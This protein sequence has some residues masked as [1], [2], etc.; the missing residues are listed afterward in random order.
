MRL[1]IQFLISPTAQPSYIMKKI[2]TAHTAMAQ[3]V[4]SS[5]HQHAQRSAPAQAAGRSELGQPM[6]A[7]TVVPDVAMAPAPQLARKAKSRRAGHAQQANDLNDSYL[8]DEAATPLIAEAE[9]ADVVPFEVQAAEVSL[10]EI[11]SISPDLS[12]RL[13]GSTA[14]GITPMGVLQTL[15][16]PLLSTTVGGAGAA[17]EAG[18]A[19]GLLGAAAVAA[20]PRGAPA[21][22]VLAE[23]ANGGINA[24]EAADGTVVDVSLSGTRAVAGDK[25]T[26]TIDGIATA[27]ILTGADIAAGAAHVTL[28]KATLLAAGQG[29]ASVTA[30]LTDSTGLVGS[31]SPATAIQIDTVAPTAPGMGLCVENS[32]GG[33]NASEA[34]DGTV[35]SYSIAGTGAVAGDTMTVNIDGVLTSYTL[36]AA[37][38]AIGIVYINIP[39]VVL[40]AA[41]QGS[42]IVTTQLIDAAG[43]ISTLSPKTLLTVDTVTPD[44]PTGLQLMDDMGSVTGLIADNSVTDDTRPDFTGSVAADVKQVNIYDGNTR[45]AT[46]VPV[47]GV[48]RYTPSSPLVAGV[49]S[50][51]ATAL[52]AA[53]NESPKSAVIHFTV[54]D[55]TEAQL[56][57]L[58]AT[59]EVAAIDANMAA[60]AANTAQANLATAVA[61]LGTPATPAQLAAVEAKQAAAIA[62]ATDA[63]N[64]AAAATAAATAAHNAAQAGAALD[65]IGVA[66][67]LT[68]AAAASN[69]ATSANNA[70]AGSEATTDA[71]VATLGAAAETA[72]TAANAAATAATMAKTELATAVAALSNPATPEQ[73]AAVEVKQAAA[74]AAASEAA[75]QATAATAAALIAHNAAQAAN[76]VDSAGVALANAAATAA[77]ASATAANAVATSSEVTTDAQIAALG[78]AAAVA[79]TAANAAAAA[80]ITAKADL[81]AAVADLS[82]PATP[83]QLAVVEFKQAAAIAAATDAANQAAAATAAATAAHNAAVAANEADPAGVAAAN[84]AATTANASAS[85]ANTAAIGSEATTDAQVAALGAAADVAATAANAAAAVATTAKTDLAAAVAALS[86]PATP[87][88]LATVEVK[89]AAAIAATADA[90]NKATAATASALA[91]HNAAQAA[92]EVD[93]AGVAAA[94]AAA[95]AANASASAANAAAISSEVTTDAQVAALGT[96]AAVAATAAN[97]AAAAATTAK[98]D[99]AAAVAALSAPATPAE[100]TTLTAKQ[101]AAIAAATDAANKAAA[102][103]AAATAAQNAAQAANEI[104]PAGVAAANAAATAANAAATSANNAVTDSANAT[105]SQLTSLAAAA[106]AAATAASTAAAAATVAKTELAAAVTALST[107]A[108]PAELAAVEVKQAAAI[109]AATDATN[110]AAAATAAATAAHNAAQATNQVDPVAVATANAAATAANVAASAA[111]TAATGSEATTDAQVAA[112]GLAAEAAATAAN[113]AAAAATTAKTDLATAVAA[114][115]SP[116]TPEQLAAVE[117]KQAAVIAASTDAAN[118]AAVATAAATAAHN[119]AVAASEADPAGVA[120]ANAAATAAN[121]AAS[122]A[123]TAATGSE[124]TTDAQVAA[125]GSAAEAAAAAANDAATAATTAKTDLA[126]AVAALGNPSTPE[127]LAAVEVKQ[128]AA[129]AAATDAANKAA[130]ATAA[131][132]AAHNAALAANEADPAGVASANAAATAANASAVAANNAATGSEA[133]TDAQVAALGSAAEAAAAAANNAAAAATTAKTELAAT[134]AALSNPATPAQ[135][136]AVELKQAAAIASATDATNKAAAA[137][138]AATAAHNAAVAANEADPVGVAAANTAATAANASALAANNAATGSEATT[139]AQ[140][141][142][143]GS[144]AD[145]AAIAANTAAAAATAA[146][147]ELAAAV[148]ALSNPATPAQLAAVEVKQAAAIAAATD[149]TNKAAAA[150]AAATAAHN[151]AVAANEAD[152]AGV[153][154]ANTAATAANATASAAS[155][156]ATGSEATT[157]AQ[158]AALGTAA[159]TAAAAANAAAAAALAAKQSLNTALAGLGAPPTPTELAA[160]DA[161][162]IAVSTA[163]TDATNKAAAATAAASAAHNAAVAANEVDP[164]GVA[165]ANTAATAATAAAATANDATPTVTSLSIASTTGVMNKTLNAGD[166]IMFDVVMSEAVTVTGSPRLA[167]NIGGAA[168]VYALYD[169]ANS[170]ATL[171]KFKFIVLPGLNDSNGISVN[172]NAISL[173]GGTIKDAA[174]NNALLVT[175]ALTDNPNLM[176]DTAAPTSGALALAIDNG[177][178]TSDGITDN[179]QIVVSDLESGATW[180][181]S[182]NAG[183]SW[184]TGIGNSFSL[185]AG[186]YAANAIQVRQTDAAGNVQTVISAKNAAAITVVAPVTINTVSADGIMASNEALVVSGTAAA[187]AAVVLSFSNQ[188]VNVTADAA[189]N[190]SYNGGATVTGSTLPTNG[191]ITVQQTVG[192]LT[193]NASTNFTVFSL[194][195]SSPIDGANTLNAAAN[196]TLTFNEAAVKGTGTIAIYKVSDNT[197][198]ESFDA[199]TSTRITGWNGTTLTVDPTNNLSY[200]TGYYVKVGASAV[201]D[202]AGN[203]YAGINDNTTLNFVTLNADGSAVAKPVLT[204]NNLTTPWASVLESGSSLLSTA[205]KVNTSNNLLTNFGTAMTAGDDVTQLQTLTAFGGSLNLFGTAY[206]GVYVTSNGYVTFGTSTTIYASV[207]LASWVGSY[208]IISGFLTDSDTA[209]A[210][211]LSTGGTSTG[212][213]KAYFRQDTNGIIVTYDDISQHTVT[214]PSDN[215]Q[216]NAFQ[217]KLTQSAFNGKTYQV[218]E[219]VYEN[220]SWSMGGASSVPQAGWSAGSGKPYAVTSW[221][222]NTTTSLTAESTSN[223]GRNGVWRWAI[224]ATTGQQVDIYNP[225]PLSRFTTTVSSVATFSATASGTAS[226]TLLTDS[227]GRFTLDTSTS[228]VTVKT[229]A[230]AVFDVS[231]VSTDLLVRVTDSLTGLTSDQTVTVYL[232]DRIG[233]A[234]DNVMG[235]RTTTE[236]TDLNTATSLWIDGAAGFDTLKLLASATNLDLTVINDTAIKNVEK[237]DLSATG[238]QTLTL[239][240]ADVSAMSSTNLIHTGTVSADGHTWTNVTGT[241]LSATT[242]SYQLVVDGGS[243]DTLVLKAGTGLWVNVGT[244]SNGTNTYNVLQNSSTDTQVFVQTGVVLPPLLVLGNPSDNGYLMNVSNNLALT[245]DQTVVKGTGTLVLYKADGTL[246]ESF[247]AATSTLVTGWGSNTLTIN[248]TSDL[249]ASTGYYI[250]VTDSAIQNSAGKTFAGITDATSYNFT[251]VG[252]DGSFVSSQTYVGTASSSLGYSVSGAGDVNGD[253]YDDFIVGAKDA[254]SAYV[255]FGNASGQIADLA[256]G[257]I[258]PASGIKISGATGLGYSVSGVGDFNGDGYADVLVGAYNNAGAAYVIYGGTNLAN[259]VIDAS[260]NVA[261]SVG[262]KINGAIDNW[263]GSTVSSAGDINGDGLADVLVGGVGTGNN[264]VGYVV[265]GRAGGVAVDLG[266]GTIATSN[267]FK[268][269]AALTGFGRTISSAGDVNGDGLADLVMGGTNNNAFVVYGNATSTA[270]S[271]NTSIAASAGFQIVSVQTSANLGAKLVSSAGDVNGDGLADVIVGAH[272]ANAAYVVYGNTTGAT[273]NIDST[274]GIAASSGFRILGTS[275]ALGYWVSGAGDINGD[276]LADVLVGSSTANGFAYVVYGNATGASVSIDASGVIAAANGFKITGVTSGSFGASVSSMGDFNGDGLG[277]LIFGSLNSGGAYNVLMGGT[278]WV[279]NAINLTGTTASEAVMGTTGSDTLTGGGGVDRFYAGAGNDTIVLTASDVTNLAS[280]TAGGPK[281]LVSGGNGFDTI[282]MSGGAA[283]D[284]TSISNA[285][286]MG[287]EENSRIESIER[288]DLATDTAAN[289]LTLTARDVKD[290]TSFNVFHTGTA[291]VDGNIWS[292]VSGTALSASTKFHQLLVDGGSNDALTLAADTGFWTNAGTVSNGASNYTV[293]QNAGTNTQVLVKSGVVVTNN[294]SVAPVVID[295]NHDGVLSYGHVTM[296]VNGDGQADTTAWAGAQDGVLVWDKYQDN[297]VHD[298]S[299]YAFTQ[300][301]GKTDLQGLIAAF[302][303]NHDGVFDARDAKFAQFS[304]WQDANQNGVSDAGEVHSLIE[305]GIASINLVSDGVARNPADGVQEAGR[306]TATGTDGQS[307]LVADAAFEFHTVPATTTTT[308]TASTSTVLAKSASASV[309]SLVDVLPAPEWQAHDVTSA[310]VAYS[311]NSVTALTDGLL[312]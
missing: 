69:A 263:L 62:A 233:T 107:P 121:A 212:T 37:D 213:G 182:T 61:A 95:T 193:T 168:G 34:A 162:Q 248:P 164:A 15:A 259:V 234:T 152:P 92:H 186:T 202:L 88:E 132:T 149:A 191:V 41:G 78:A 165:T 82:S 74:I 250:K 68:A 50:F 84:A 277:D 291:S 223:I 119:A 198:V 256:T 103:T 19:S 261:T 289:T 264:A 38:L 126:I 116:A 54:T 292:N 63:A 300:Y 166:I 4:Q 272:G 274:G 232:T 17:T 228:T 180:Q 111:N 254:N 192:G 210:G 167:L 6:L 31:I 176:V 295:M 47:A 225:T 200:G 171:L 59:A 8:V 163:V 236:M 94:N 147:T 179:G 190:W 77:N 174:G 123:N 33:I 91:A 169:S 281:A 308:T 133:T 20:T 101:N 99:L 184:A 242:T 76:E 220:I 80:A 102:A 96:A 211:K 79:A 142:A 265:Y 301:G 45:I 307:V 237:I 140:V 207:N 160:I 136:A 287:L 10:T 156:A 230:G 14:G 285:G 217:I 143:L 249:L 310:H 36:M 25:L 157:D 108:T 67:A 11:A 276:G 282:R 42:A 229:V 205:N 146:K 65:P 305:A 98:A 269:N 27:Y 138:A 71:Q 201:K 224:D 5:D 49:Y 195:G 243:N 268:I 86:S 66:S 44:A 170:T 3:T 158:V 7:A 270:P 109:A 23:A 266:A 159:D 297:V 239:S 189:G 303:T 29:A 115:G 117:L 203:A 226:Y 161:Q 214:G 129:I 194:T 221:S 128:A 283:L 306:T 12:G 135:L 231:E 181:Y 252:A 219:L 267:G 90:A 197:L 43:N 105:G 104:D 183:G 85:A 83:A 235:L 311:L 245:F 144:A 271:I 112:L 173:N 296:D 22:P 9:V 46:V 246:V 124:A 241:A 238:A 175:N 172:A 56:T 208:P 209:I 273:V 294:D 216:G 293:Y 206:T 52:D 26:V 286:A 127:Q 39:K 284:L 122:A 227:N 81:A 258:A 153:S 18:A 196:L 55:V 48:W 24:T 309:L 275:G 32:L 299:Q 185:S 28:T 118:K 312:Y 302:D 64:K 154:A 145:T 251:T 16:G 30:V 255:V 130:V 141:A 113:T 279:S 114:L 204:V 187:N 131:A 100:L 87:A 148:A 278:Q 57:A 218:I 97:T 73:L 240:N 21:A 72:A 2:I 60:T 304:V 288:I 93:A 120:S 151:A 53:R 1:S 280:N 137:I 139:D 199:A 290:M 188:V 155:N 298:S 134:V 40:D 75:N 222:G 215:T 257:S 58:G 247:D 177:N 70:A 13:G 106:E 125:L 178:S 89:Q 110:K 35:I 253:G 262:F 51:S 244:V 150:T 260:Q